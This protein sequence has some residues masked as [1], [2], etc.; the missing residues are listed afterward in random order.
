MREAVGGERHLPAPR[1]A[2][3]LPGEL[4][5]HRRHPL[6]EGVARL[7]RRGAAEALPAAEDHAPVGVEPPVRQQVAGVVDHA[8]GGQHRVL[9]LGSERVGGDDERAHRQHLRLQGARSPVG[10]GVDGEQHV[11]AADGPSPDDLDGAAI[12]AH[13]DS[14][15]AGV[16]PRTG[17]LGPAHETGVEAGRVQ[18]A[19][20]LDHQPALE[21]LRADLVAELAGGDEP[22]AGARHLGGPVGEGP[23]ESALRVPWATSRRPE[24]T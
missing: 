13:A 23:E 12:G 17:R 22:G 24:R 19:A 11:A 18:P 5:V 6:V 8:P 2:H 20:A 7:F 9:E 16:Q 10:V 21:G 15:V 3:R 14:G 4:R 1:P